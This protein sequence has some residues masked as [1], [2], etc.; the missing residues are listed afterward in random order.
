MTCTPPSPRGK[1]PHNIRVVAESDD[2]IVIDKPAHLAAHPSKPDGS[3]TLW[4]AVRELLAYEL[5]NGGQ[6]SIINRLDRETSGLTLIAKNA[7]AARRFGMAMERRAIH[8]EYLALVLGW[9]EHDLYEIDAPLARLGDFKTSR[10]WLKQAVHPAG[11]PARTTVRVEQRFGRET[12]NGSRFALLRALPETGRMH[13]IRV[14]L[15]HIGHPV[16]G[17]KIYGPD[18]SCYLRFIETGWTPALEQQLLLSRHALHSQVLEIP[19]EN[20]RWTAPLPRDM[21]TWAAA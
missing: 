6:V 1:T 7:A 13:Q 9:P 2:W 12:S 11:A 20:L 3:F 17:D 10:I 18:E 16:V 4:H 15:A 8:K 5:A 14:H 21:A 19:G